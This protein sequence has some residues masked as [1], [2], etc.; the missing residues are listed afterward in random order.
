MQK[1]TRNPKSE[2]ALKHEWGCHYIGLFQPDGDGA[3]FYSLWFRHCTGVQ[4]NI[5][6]SQQ[7]CVFFS[8]EYN[9]KYYSYEI[10]TL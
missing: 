9:N 2:A 1:T 10:C 8:L 3:D 7:N 5:Y 6:M 4:C